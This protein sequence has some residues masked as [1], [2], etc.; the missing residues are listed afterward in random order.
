MLVNLLSN[1]V[2]FTPE[3]RRDQGGHSPFEKFRQTS[4]AKTVRDARPGPGLL[5]CRHLVEAH[6]GRIRS[7]S[8]VGRGSRFVFRLSAGRG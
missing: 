3:Q 7:E 5:N 1:A 4:T 6:G 2:K 8:E